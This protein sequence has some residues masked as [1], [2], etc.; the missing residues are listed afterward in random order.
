M[1]TVDSTNPIFPQG[2]EDAIVS[3]VAETYGAAG[4]Q[5]FTQACPYSG[6]NLYAWNNMGP[7]KYYKE[8]VCT[9]TLPFPLFTFAGLN[10]DGIPPGNKIK[11]SLYA[12]PYYFTNLIQSNVPMTNTTAIRDIVQLTQSNGNVPAYSIGVAVIDMF[13]Q[14]RMVSKPNPLNDVRLLKIRQIQAQTHT[15]ASTS[16]Q[17]PLS[18][19]IRNLKY[20]LSC[21]LH[22]NRYGKNASPSDFSDGIGVNTGAVSCVNL[23]RFQYHG[24][25]YPSNDYNID[26][27]NKVICGA[28][29]S[30]ME[31][32]RLLADVVGNSGVRDD[33]NGS[34]YDLSKI[35]TEPIFCFKIG[36]LPNNTESTLNVTVNCT[37]GAYT[38]SSSAILIVC[39]YDQDFE[40]PYVNGTI[41]DASCRLID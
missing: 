15:L 22:S 32:Y 33:R 26:N 35:A 10:P 11:I 21:F 17:F 3:T 5:N 9:F 20:I 37:K 34:L 16:E 31:L 23:V 19:P 14:V 28:G 8:N 38:G 30:S 1:N 13:L 18:V 40:I 29:N 27:T 2:I 25:S 6:H 12:S 7:F 41:D 36:D 4:A 39:L 24:K